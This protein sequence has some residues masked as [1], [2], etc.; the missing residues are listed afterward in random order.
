MRQVLHLAAQ[1]D[2]PPVLEKV[3]AHDERALALGH[4]KAVGNDMAEGWAK[5][6]ATENNHTVW[7]GM[8]ALHDD[9]VIVVDAGGRFVR[10]V[11]QQLAGI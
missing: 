4:P 5:R 1:L 2:S 10:D 9:P 7:P 11:T 6:A 3:K 8:V